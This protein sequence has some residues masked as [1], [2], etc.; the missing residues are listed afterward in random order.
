MSERATC[1]SMPAG[2]TRR[3][4][5]LSNLALFGANVVKAEQRVA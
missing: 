1:Q 3:A 4:Q 2:A 5:V